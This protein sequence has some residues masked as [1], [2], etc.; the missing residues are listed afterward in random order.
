MRKFITDKKTGKLIEVKDDSSFKVNGK[1][2]DREALHYSTLNDE[3]NSINADL[4]LISKGWVDSKT[5]ESTIKKYNKLNNK[6]SGYADYLKRKGDTENLSLVTEMLESSKLNTESLYAR[7]NV[8]KKFDNSKDY[9]NALW[10]NKYSPYTYKGLKE[11]KTTDEYKNL[12]KEEKKFV[13]NF[14][15]NY[16]YSDKDSYKQNIADINAQINELEGK[17]DANYMSVETTGFIGAVPVTE[18]KTKYEDEIN[19]LKAQKKAIEKNYSNYKT[20][21]KFD[22]YVHITKNADFD[23]ISQNTMLEYVIDSSKDFTAYN[24][25]LNPKKAKD[26]AKYLATKNANKGETLMLRW[27]DSPVGLLDSP[28]EGAKFDYLEED[29]INTFFYLL[30][31]DEKKAQNFLNEM[32]KTLN[33]RMTEDVQKNAIEYAEKHPVLATGLRTLSNLGSGMGIGEDIYNTI[34]GKGIDQNSAS[35]SNAHITNAITSTVGEMAGQSDALGGIFQTEVFGD[36]LGTHLYNAGTTTIDMGIDILIGKGLASG[37]AKMS[38]TALTSASKKAIT[39]K[40][41]QFIMSSQAGANGIIS[42]KDRGLSD[43]QALSIGT[44]DAITEWLTEKYSIEAFLS[45]PKNIWKYIRNNAIA[46]PSEEI[47]SGILGRIS[48]DIIAGEDSEFNLSMQKY[49]LDGL[50]TKEAFNQA[51]KDFLRQLGAEG[52]TALLSGGTMG[53]MGAIADVKSRYQTG[54]FLNKNQSVDGLKSLA[55]S[56]GVNIQNKLSNTK[57]GSLYREVGKKVGEKLDSANISRFKSAIALRLT[58]LGETKANALKIA[59][60]IVK[61][62]SGKSLTAEEIKAISSSENGKAVLKDIKSSM[63]GE[64]VAWIER[65]DTRTTNKLNSAIQT[66]TEFNRLTEHKTNKQQKA[67]NNAEGYKVDENATV[68]PQSISVDSDGKVVIN[69]E[70]GLQKATE[71]VVDSNTAI[72]LGYADDMK[73]EEKRV[74]VENFDGKMDAD[75]YY[76]SFEL[77]KAYAINGASITVGRA[78]KGRLTD[79]QVLNFYKYG[80]TQRKSEIAKK[81]QAL[82]KLV[83]DFNKEHHEVKQGSFNATAIENVKLNR[84]QN[85]VVRIFKALASRGVNVVIENS[86][87]EQRANNFENGWYDPETNTV[88]IDL[89]AGIIEAK[90]IVKDTMINTMSH[91]LLHWAKFKSPELYEALKDMVLDAMDKSNYDSHIR[92]KSEMD[93]LLEKEAYKN[94]SKEELMDVAIEEIV[95]RACEGNLAKSELMTE[96]INDLSAR[97]EGLVE[98]FTEAIHEAVKTVK[99][100]LG[101]L[102][103]YA[104]NLSEEAQTMQEVLGQDLDAFVKAY[105]NLVKSA[106]ETNQALADDN[107]TIKKSD[108]KYSPRDFG[109]EDFNK[110]SLNNIKMR[111]GIIIDNE[112]ELNSHITKALTSNKKENLYLGAISENTKAKIEQELGIAIFKKLGQYTYSISYDD[113]RHISKHYSTNAEIINTVKVLFGMLNNYD[114]ISNET[115]KDGQNRIILEKSLPNA[116]YLT[117]NIVSSKRR[118]LDLTTIY[119]TKKNKNGAQLNQPDISNSKDVAQLESNSAINSISSKT[120]ISQEKF[121]DRDTAYMD[122]VNRGD[123]ETAQRLVDEVAKANG[124]I[125]SGYHGTDIRFTI[126]DREKT[127]TSNDFGKGFYFTS[128]QVEAQKYQNDDAF[129]DTYNKIDGIAYD[130]ALERIE[131]MGED[132][133][134]D[135][136]F[137][138]LYNEEFDK[139]LKRRTDEGA[140]INAYL[141]MEKPFIVSTTNWITEEEALDIAQNTMYVD[142]VPDDVAISDWVHSI[143]FYAKQHDGKVDTHQFANNM[144]HSVKLTSALLTQGIYDGILDYSV[145]TKFDST[146]DYHAIALYPNKIK[147][148]APVTYDDNGNVIPLSKRFDNDNKDIRYS[149]RDIE[150]LETLNNQLRQKQNE[151]YDLAIQLRKFDKKEAEDKLYSVM[152]KKG[153]TQEELD[154][155]LFEYAEWERNSG[156]ADMHKKETALKDELKFL[157]REV[158]KIEDSLHKK[159]LEQISHFTDEEIQK[160]VSKAVRRYHTTSRLSN[161]SY[162]LTTGS[163]L[164]FSDGQGYRVK[165][166]R[167]ISE[168]LDLP[169]YAEYSDGMIAF[170]NMGNIRLQTYGIDISA[171]PNSKQFSALRDVIIKTMREYDEFTVDFSRKDG[172]SAG[173]ITYPKGTVSSK[174]FADIKNFFENGV[175]PEQE[176][177][178]RDFIY[179]DRDIKRID[180]KGNELSKAQ[181]N[182]FANSK[183]RD[184]KGRLILVYHGTTANFNIF[185]KG[186]VGYHFGTKGAARGRV[187]YS[188]DVI[189][190][191]CYLNITNPIIFDEDLGSWDADYSLTKELY[192]RGILSKEEAEAIL[193]TDSKLYKRTTESANKKLAEVLLSKGYDGIEYQNTFETKKPTKSYIAFSPEQIKLTTNTNPTSNPDIRYADRNWHT[194]MSNAEVTRI[195]RL[196]KHELFRTDNYIDKGNKWL[197]ND[198]GKIPYFALYSTYDEENPTVM[199]A[200]KGNRAKQEYIWL[201][202]FIKEKEKFENARD[203]LRGKVINEVLVRFGYALDKGSGNSRNNANTGSNNRNA[204]IHSTTHGV[205][206]SEAL[207]N[208]IRNIGEAQKRDSIKKSDREVPSVRSTLVDALDSITESEIDKQTLNK[209]RAMLDKIE[210]SSNELAEAKRELHDMMFTKGKYDAEKKKKLE[211]TIKA[212]E[213]TVNQWDKSLLRL[214]STKPFKDVVEREKKKAMQKQKVKGK[215]AMKDY[216]ESI[217]HRTEL[218]KLTD[219]AMKLNKWLNENSKDHHIPDALKTPV[220]ELLNALDFSSKRLLKGGKETQKDVSFA[221]RMRKVKEMLNDNSIQK[222]GMIFLEDGIREDFDKLVDTVGRLAEEHSQTENVLNNMTAEQLHNLNQVLRSITSSIAQANELIANNQYRNAFDCIRQT[223]KDAYDSPEYKSGSNTKLSKAWRGIKTFINW[224]NE[225][226]YYVFERFGKGGQSIFEELQDGQ[227]KLAFLEKQILDFKTKTFTDKQVADWEKEIHEFNVDGKTIKVSTAQLM[228]YYM[229]SLRKQAQGHLMGCGIGFGDMYDKEAQVYN[230]HIT[231]E[232]MVKMFEVLTNEQIEIAKKLQNFM[233]TVCGEWGNKISMARYGIRAF[234]ETDY[235]PLKV[236]ANELNSEN[237]IQQEESLYRLLN[238]SFTKQTNPKANNRVMIYSIFDVFAQHTSDMAKYNAMALPLLDALK[239]F[240]FRTTR[241]NGKT[242]FSLDSVSVKDALDHAYGEQAQTYVLDLLKDLN[243]SK[244]SGRSQ[245]DGFLS[246]LMSGSKIAMVAFNFRVA[247]LQATSYM[248]AS[249]EINPLYLLKG[250]IRLPSIKK[251]EKYS[252][253]ALWKSFGNYDINITR[254]MTE[255]IKGKSKKDKLVEITL[256]GAEWGD[257][258]TWGYLWNACESEIKSTTDLKVGT[259]EFNQAVA[260]RLR[261]IIYRTQVVDSILTRSPLMRSKDNATKSVTAF[262]SEPILRYN[263]VQSQIFKTIQDSKKLG[264][265]TSLSKHKGGLTRVVGVY[266]SSVALTTIVQ[267]LVDAMRDD[268]DEKEFYEK[269]LEAWKENGLAEITLLNKLPI[270]SDVYFAIMSYKKYGNV[271]ENSP[272]YTAWITKTI[273]A[274]DGWKK[275]AQGKGKATT[276]KNLYDTAQAISSLWGLPIGN[277]MREFVT[278]WNNTIG[279]MD[280]NLKLKKYED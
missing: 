249:N 234:T 142:N 141:K 33:L 240:N 242:E 191:E 109:L 8:Y 23:S 207:L 212:K 236:D 233:A 138:K 265:K 226:P 123:M 148:S 27:S 200:S 137:T 149:D 277:A 136:L 274:V 199:Y 1:S 241:P 143:K 24:T 210:K 69:T 52:F 61:K 195:E 88:H 65:I 139:E 110:D 35:H 43:I 58:N 198:R 71:T 214:E 19:K 216:R 40:T 50:S 185:K 218:K 266:V 188:K 248:W 98:K 146:A 184:N 208:C 15:T 31:D 76:N 252:G 255:A 263:M 140:T 122:A 21:N 77:Q 83:E 245:M 175:I 160:Y 56:E 134:D 157:R 270:L 158:Q 64:S 264:I 215:E 221:E 201:M 267:S 225:L 189:I 108:V 90:K 107:K 247:L 194:G 5:M 159:L 37:F 278:L 78:N 60:A 145:G 213:N 177:G 150:R 133:S 105:D 172:H 121:S 38:G 262:M 251:A 20:V 203:D 187:G 144:G 91:E 86:T 45:D 237:A 127:S 155:A 6:L 261:E 132:A 254:N 102:D 3:I 115:L 211:A 163:M 47:A 166:H 176:S 29:E 74:F 30:E 206:P 34:S 10:Y 156:Y 46:E 101:I 279:V 99:D 180:S 205:R 84:K 183:V 62:Q 80:L 51:T 250:L 49:L 129:G 257:K 103:E 192:A 128:S 119:I 147:D 13:D 227:D 178:I 82:D 26:V 125:I 22:E 219:R 276:Y 55:T 168:I 57:V 232:E 230:A 224:S 243:S 222:N 73:G 39:G 42:A 174:I 7:Q 151:I 92:I 48:D 269:F 220:A 271:Y 94:L 256:K 75:A 135:A 66:K 182:F 202:D 53:T 162:L 18:T 17:A 231:A 118:S 104:D 131:S 161:A 273:K 259:D 280:E 89:N 4:N 258:I 41:V 244:G 116:D 190:K 275:L 197:Y 112:T 63:K 130:N 106:L 114:N 169:D 14:A 124:Y 235:Y 181:Q 126:F 85:A 100:F 204:R 81:Q 12:G 72:M 272:M 153:V 246:K 239:W 25:T 95:A 70:N 2:V 253:I 268:D 229:L 67:R 228:G 11:F 238:M 209:Y 97:G 93:R 170:M 164:D 59:D 96:I 193:F 32:S 173:S 179:S 113:I 152:D 36:E 223:L 9:N 167:E 79:S 260:K 117:V 196:A 165:D 68:K 16:G 44:A 217:A 111:G 87:A 171:M 54:R 186:D 154:D 28:S 120:K